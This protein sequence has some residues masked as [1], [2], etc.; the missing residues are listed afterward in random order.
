MDA[1]ICTIFESHYY[2]G[3]AALTNSLYKQGYRGEIF[4][5]YRG[6]LPNCF[7]HANKNDRIGWPEARTCIVAK[8]LEIHFLPI[9]TEYHLANFKP[10]FM[11]TL[12]KGLAKSKM[13][14]FYFDP[15]IILTVDWSFIESWVNFGVSLCEDVNS[16]LSQ[17]HPR[18]MAWR[19]YFSEKEIFLQFKSA[20]Y[21][22]SGFIGL[23]QAN[24]DFLVKW[25]EIQES[26]ALQIGGLNRSPFNG[27]GLLSPIDGLIML[28]FQEQIRM[29]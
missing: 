23:C 24:M 10:D 14:M 8:G 17:F 29:H 9:T 16:P 26:I 21:A 19:K 7:A 12:W 6:G 15:D 5:G 2:H 28:P 3:V 27:K 11:L 4:A 18:R 22:N 20:I 25:K 1:V 13:K